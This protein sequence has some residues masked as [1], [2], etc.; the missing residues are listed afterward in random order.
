MALT[1]IEL[2]MLKDGILTADTAGR[3]KMA[4]G[5]VDDAKMLAGVGNVRQILESKNPSAAPYS[6][7]WSGHQDKGAVNSSTWYVNI[8]PKS[9]SSKMLIMFPIAWRKSTWNVGIQVGAMINGTVAND[10]T[11]VGAISNAYVGHRINVQSDGY[12]D[13]VFMSVYNFQ[14]TSQHTI[15]FNL[16][17]YDENSSFTFEIMDRSRIIVAEIA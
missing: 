10:I 14:N 15:K 5:F 3:L 9:A 16:W 2:G 6:G 12:F 8:T 17:I 11:G 4:D 13:N 7:S 1:Q